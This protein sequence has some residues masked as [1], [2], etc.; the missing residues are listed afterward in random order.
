MIK[1]GEHLKRVSITILLA[2]AVVSFWRGIWG[3]MDLYL[4][5]KNPTASFAISIIIGIIIVYSIKHKLKLLI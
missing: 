1:G 3:I 5:P 4:L 2:L